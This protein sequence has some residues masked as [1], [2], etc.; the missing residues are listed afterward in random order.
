M[1]NSAFYDAGPLKQIAINLFYGWGYNFYRVENQLRSDD[2]LIRGQ[3]GALLGAAHASVRSAESAYR[4]EF[5]P[6]PSRQKPFPEAS[7]VS[8]AQAIERLAGSIGA[9]EGLITALPAPESDRMSQRYRQEAETLAQL[10]DCDERLIGQS[11]LL[12]ATVDRKDGAWLIANAAAVEDGVHAI[13]E[14]LRERQE[15]LL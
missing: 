6:P 4:R 2:L 13:S 8:G 14:T 5:L 7:A 9:L 3:A 15:I 12:R 1:A 11:E 10:L